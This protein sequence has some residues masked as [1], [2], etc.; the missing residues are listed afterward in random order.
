MSPSGSVI[1]APVRTAAAAA[2]GGAPHST[3]GELEPPAGRSFWSPGAS[4]PVP[5]PGKPADPCDCPQRPTRS[6]GASTGPQQP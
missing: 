4:V 5:K 3:D 6:G 2:A 1:P